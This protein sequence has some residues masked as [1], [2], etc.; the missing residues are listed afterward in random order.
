[1]G[2]A[3]IG[4]AISDD[5]RRMAVPLGTVRTGGP[6][7]LRATAALLRGHR[8]TPRRGVRGGGRGGPRR[9]GAAEG[10]A[11]V[12]RGGRTRPAGEWREWSRSPEDDRSLG[13]DRD[14][15]VLAPHRP[16]P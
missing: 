1:L 4:V 12:H 15:A 7:D 5:A 16:A 14:P 9:P 6:P 3:R 2:D 10:R 8:A 11:P 13:R